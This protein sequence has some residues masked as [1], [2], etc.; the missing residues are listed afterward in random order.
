M[1]KRIVLK[2]KIVKAN[3]NQYLVIVDETTGVNYLCVPTSGVTPL[4]NPDGSLIVTPI[5]KE[6]R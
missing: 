5:D 6:V 1:K 2:K 3:K 4:Y